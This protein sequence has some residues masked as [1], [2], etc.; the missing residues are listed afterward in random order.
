MELEVDRYVHNGS[1]SHDDTAGLAEWTD[2]SLEG[3]I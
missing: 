2:L 3:I 1:H